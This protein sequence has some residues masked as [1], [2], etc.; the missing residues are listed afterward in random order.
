M[1]KK[2]LV[3]G[4]EILTVI[5]FAYSLE[6]DYYT[7]VPSE[8]AFPLISPRVKMIGQDFLGIISDIESD[9]IEN[10][11]L[12]SLLKYNEV[13]ASFLPY[14][15]DKIRYPISLS[16]LYPK[17]FS[18]R[19]GLGFQN[20]YVYS[21]KATNYVI[22]DM[23]VYQFYNF[24]AYQQLLFISFS[25]TPNLNISPF[26]IITKSPYRYKNEYNFPLEAS[27]NFDYTHYS[28]SQLNYDYHSQQFGLGM[29]YNWERNSLQLATSL[30]KGNTKN[31]CNGQDST[32]DIHCFQ[33]C[34]TF[35]N[36]YRYYLY[37]DISYDKDTLINQGAKQNYASRLSCRWCKELNN[38]EIINTFVDFRHTSEESTWTNLDSKLYIHIDSNYYRWRNYPYPESTRITSDSI[39]DYYKYYTNTSGKHTETNLSIGFGYEI[40]ISHFVKSFVGI[41][42]T[43]NFESD[44]TRREYTTVG[45][46]DS[47]SD[48]T[49]TSRYSAQ[50]NTRFIVSVPA[51][52]EY[53]RLNPLIIRWGVNF[54][55]FHEWISTKYDWDTLYTNQH[56][57]YFEFVYSFGLGLKISQKLYINA[58]NT[59]N[60]FSTP[61][62]FTINECGAQV[63]Y[64]F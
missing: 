51:G 49:T 46:T 54:R 27:N 7:Q 57:E 50:K 10:P 59:G 52:W 47:T 21:S 48:T 4:V 42:S 41:K 6:N 30:L 26:Y 13:N 45:Y 28:I 15:I 20:Q 61:W 29:N 44:S 19:V 36:S 22:N 14:V 3:L 25:A 9:I 11:S 34:D 12:L 43:F 56:N 39:Q 62:L 40:P 55:S 31:N 18:S 35:G 37:K 60:L 64:I 38:N 24:W 23:D 17:L 58:Y 8:P 16:F 1:H 2:I 53:I 63:R 33:Y 32:W 5:N